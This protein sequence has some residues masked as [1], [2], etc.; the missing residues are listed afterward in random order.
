[1]PAPPHSTCEQACV[2]LTTLSDLC[3]VLKLLCLRLRHLWG[4]PHEGN[5][6]RFIT[7]WCALSTN[8]PQKTPTVHSWLMGC[9]AEPM[10]HFLKKNISP[11]L[12]SPFLWFHILCQKDKVLCV[13]PNKGPQFFP[14]IMCLSCWERKEM[15]W[16]WMVYCHSSFAALCSLL[17]CRTVGSWVALFVFLWQGAH[18]PVFFCCQ[19]KFC[20][21]VLSMF[22]FVCVKK[23]KKT[24]IVLTASLPSVVSLRKLIQNMA[25]RW[26]VG[27]SFC[28]EFACGFPLDSLPQSKDI[29]VGFIGD[30]K[31][32]IQ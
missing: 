4:C 28:G 12:S 15:K 25:G 23:N 17:F 11:F 3:V 5:A 1:M 19:V 32:P 27:G 10:N 31:L 9:S 16:R 29:H 7:Y 2:V 20:L 26:R 21:F 14:A 18:T 30:C 13:P 6:Q 24:P 22:C 8:A